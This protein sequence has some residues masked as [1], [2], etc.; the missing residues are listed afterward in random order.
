MHGTA[1]QREAEQ[2]SGGHPSLEE[3]RLTCRLR[4]INA[5]VNH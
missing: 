3:L 1:L 2:P 5:V 4:R